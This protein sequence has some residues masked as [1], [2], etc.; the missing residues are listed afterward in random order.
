MEKQALS[1]VK[2]A[3]FSWS[4]AGPL[5][6]DYLAN[7]GAR[8]IHVES[9]IKP[10]VL[11][12]CEPF[13]DDIPGLNRSG[14]F[15]TYNSNKYG[16]S[17]NLR[18]PRSI[19]I[20]KR[21]VAWADIV[22]ENFTPG[23]MARLGL[24]YEELRKIKP[25][26]IM[27]SLSAQGQSGPHAAVPAYG[28]QLTSLA[29][30]PYI[31]G[32]ADGEPITPFGAY[33]DFLSPRFGAA[34]LLAA[35]DY[36]RRTGKGQY[37]DLSQIECAMHFISPFLLDCAVNN[38]EAGRKGNCCSYA[39]PHGCYKCCGEDQW[40]TIAVF[41]DAEW[42][43]FLSVLGNPEW[44][45]EAKFATLLGRKQNEEEL[46][47]RVEEWTINYSPEEV[48]TLMQKAG[49]AAGMVQS[50]KGV[51]HDPHL[52]Y[53]DHFRML[54]HREM[55]PYAYEAPAFKLSKTPCELRQ[56]SPCLGEHNDYVY[57]QILGM[58]DEEFVELLTEGVF[59]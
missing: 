2:V 22:A 33:T 11:R 10:D 4:I 6:I 45:K 52:N 13:K 57:T 40:C 1:G 23:V 9:S 49:V 27:I 41:T 47:K 55:G 53:R 12:T 38:R 43:G 31:T 58:S 26:I 8:V 28:N 34:A 56:A 51:H 7:H 36:H 42:A 30:L 18:H 17:L 54:H 24:D 59:D 48:M 50:N 35:L 32:W 5:T 46:D 3:D 25:D 39:A 21:I 15:A 44:A 14:Y 29:G 20:A 19:E 16:I 37:L